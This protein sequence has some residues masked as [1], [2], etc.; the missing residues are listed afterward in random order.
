MSRDRALAWLI[1]AAVVAYMAF[2]LWRGWALM[3]SGDPVALGMGLAV[4]VLPAI[5]AWLLFRELRFGLQ[6]QRMGREMAT[7]GSLA[8]DDLPRAPSGRVDREAADARFE[9]ERQRLESDDADWRNWYRLA[10]AYDDARDRK[11]ARAAM[12]EAV[13]R[14][15]QSR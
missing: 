3:S 7:E 2:A 4:V 15:Q 9:V 1:A 6:M 12:R 10:V 5:G 11:R 13:K 14:W 8:I